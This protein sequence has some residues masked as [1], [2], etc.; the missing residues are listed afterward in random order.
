MTGRISG[1]TDGKIVEFNSLS[2]DQKWHYLEEYWAKASKFYEIKSDL[3]VP[4][5]QVNLQ[6]KKL[7]VKPQ[8]KFRRVILLKNWKWKLDPEMKGVREG[9]FKHNHADESWKSATSPQ[10]QLYS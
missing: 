7:K 3:V 10:C 2:P 6:V 8:S 5:D 9:Y 4:D 1:K